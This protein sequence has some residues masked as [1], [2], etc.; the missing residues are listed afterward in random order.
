MT[1]SG[2]A[3]VLL[4][5]GLVLLLLA[6]RLKVRDANRPREPMEQARPE[7]LSIATRGSDR[8]RIRAIKVLRERTGLGLREANDMV[9]RWLQEEDRAGQ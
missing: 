3:I 7:V 4:A 9:K 6:H 1:A 8:D 5:C 2:V